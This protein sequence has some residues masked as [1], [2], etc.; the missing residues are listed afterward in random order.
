MRKIS[1]HITTNGN[2]PL[3]PIQNFKPAILPNNPIHRIQWKS[4]TNRIHNRLLL[5]IIITK[6][7]LIRR[8]NIQ[9]P[10]ITSY[11]T[12]VIVF[13]I[14]N[15]I[16]NSNR[17]QI[18]CH[19]FFLLFIFWAV[20]TFSGSGFAGFRRLPRLHSSTSFQNSS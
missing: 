6:F 5:T 11:A 3:L 8:P 7:P 2:R 20:P 18:N 14:L 1:V 12:L 9:T 4:L 15:Q 16:S 10:I 13:V 17:M 19:I